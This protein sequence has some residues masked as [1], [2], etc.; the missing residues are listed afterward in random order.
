MSQLR[1]LRLL[2]AAAIVAAASL[3]AFGQTAPI[4]GMVELKKADGTVEPLAGAVVEVYRMDIKSTL[5]SSKTNKKGE[6]VFA[7]LPLGGTFTLSISGPGAQ[8]QYLPGVKAGQDRLRITLSEGDGKPLAEDE[9]RKLAAQSM[10]TDGGELSAEQKKQKAEY[11]KKRAEVEAKNK[12][13]ENKNAVVQRSLKEGND[14]FE[15]KNFDVAIVKYSEG[16]DADPSFAGSAPVLLNNRGIAYRNRAI[17]KY[18]AA[19]KGDPSAK[20]EGILAA[21]KDL[22]DSVESFASS[23]TVLKGAKPGDIADPKVGETARVNALRGMKDS[24]KLMVDTRQV[25]EAVLPKA[26]EYIP[27]YIAVE[28]DAAKKAE[29]QLILA[30][31][32]RVAGD[33]EKAIAEYRKVLAASPDNL[34]GLAGIGFSLV[35]Q[36]YIDNDK[37]KLQEGADF[38]QKFASLAPDSHK[39]KS[40]ATGLIQS[41]KAEQNVTPAKSTKKK[42]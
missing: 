12:E 28:T 8:A 21:K 15:A 40:D 5:S 25:D 4:S 20:A 7:G 6:F 17:G 29:A 37:A 27:Q 14:A 42:N 13:I 26:G 24:F 19:V 9:V 10:T 32:Y 34:E 38:L 39:Y 22:N 23:L 1:S 36:G 3:V 31:L 16:I 35:N 30:D 33:S 41:L 2:F 18:N 11:D